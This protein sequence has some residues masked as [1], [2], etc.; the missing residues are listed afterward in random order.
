[1]PGVRFGKPLAFSAQLCIYDV[2]KSLVAQRP[3]PG[4]VWGLRRAKERKG[5]RRAREEGS[6]NVGTG[7]V[8]FVAFR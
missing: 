4:Q 3:A 5:Q 1:L 7:K 2:P 8:C 6:E